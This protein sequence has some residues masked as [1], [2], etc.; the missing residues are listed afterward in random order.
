MNIKVFQIL[1]LSFEIPV[2]LSEDKT[3]HFYV[4]LTEPRSQPSVC[5]WFIL[6]LQGCFCSYFLKDSV[7]LMKRNLKLVFTLV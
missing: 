2:K 7:T 1:G 6:A 4:C 3:K 5:E